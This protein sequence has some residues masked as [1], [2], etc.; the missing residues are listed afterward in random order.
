MRGAAKNLECVPLIPERWDDF[1]TLFGP[2]GACAGC[3]CMYWRL[4]RS[5]FVR[6]KGDGNRDAMRDLVQAALLPAFSGT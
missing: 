3:W 2:K 4:K 1:A 6:G 5:D